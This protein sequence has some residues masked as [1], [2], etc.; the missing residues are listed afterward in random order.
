MPSFCYQDCELH[1][2]RRS[3]AMAPSENGRD[4]T[5]IF[6]HGLG[7]DCEQALTL[8][9]DLNHVQVI[10]IDMPGHGH[11]LCSEKETFS[12]HFFAEVVL[13]LMDKLE[14]S[15]AVLGGISMGAGTSLQV[16]MRWPQRVEGLLLQRPAWLNA[17][18]LAHLDIVAS[19][20]LWIDAG[21]LE[22]AKQQ[23]DG[24]DLLRDLENHNPNCARS[25]RGLLSR[26]QAKSAALVLPTLVM[27]QPYDY[28]EQLNAIRVPTLVFA[29]DHDPLHPIKLA[30]TLAEQLANNTYRE[31][32]SPYL[33]P[34]QHLQQFTQ[35][36][37]HFLNRLA[38]PECL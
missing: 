17:S 24:H 28:P 20:G 37:Q 23:L 4:Q 29:C 8:C 26:E 18:A 19:C 7:A 11:S 25:I 10:S 15:S 21:G 6:L 35:W 16:A 30:Q 2:Q 1:Y 22:H 27:D 13:A 5:L 36:A 12:F 33:Q 3:P 32:P 14:L 38:V 34:A 31:I 9:A